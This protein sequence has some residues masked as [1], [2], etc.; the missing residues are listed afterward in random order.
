MEADMIKTGLAAPGPPPVPLGPAA[1]ALK[2]C[3]KH[4][5]VWLAEKLPTV[6]V[7]IKTSLN[8]Q[9]REGPTSASEYSYAAEFR[10]QRAPNSFFAHSGDFVVARGIR[11]TAEF[12]ERGEIKIFK[13]GRG[14]HYVRA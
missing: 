2:L 1:L 3:P 12:A 5:T 6:N 13:I 9:S 8:Q 4:L 10:S 11:F 7:L 14:F